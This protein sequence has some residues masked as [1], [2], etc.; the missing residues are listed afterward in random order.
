[1][2]VSTSDRGMSMGIGPAPALNVG[3][4]GLNHAGTR[5][6]LDVLM[7]MHQSWGARTPPPPQ[8]L[9]PAGMNPSSKVQIVVRDLQKWSKRRVNP[10]AHL[11]LRALR[12]AR[13]HVHLASSC[14]LALDVHVFTA[15]L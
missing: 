9:R 12:G 10:E 4:S 6:R 14:G 5:T 7:L 2:I 1:M 11:P 15:F 8:R 13:C 3:L